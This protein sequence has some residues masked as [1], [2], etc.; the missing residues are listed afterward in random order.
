MEANIQQK[1]KGGRPTIVFTQPEDKT[2]KATAKKMHTIASK[3]MLGKCSAKLFGLPSNPIFAGN[4]E[5]IPTENKNLG[6]GCLE[7]ELEFFKKN[8][9]NIKKIILDCNADSIRQIQHVSKDGVTV[10]RLLLDLKRMA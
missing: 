10:V 4:F 3:L 5:G 7:F 1:P 6:M 2:V 9:E 8:E